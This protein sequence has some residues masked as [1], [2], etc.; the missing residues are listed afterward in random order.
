[1]NADAT[2]HLQHAAGVLPDDARVLFDR[3]SHA[4][5]F[6]LPIYQAVR[7]TASAKPNRFIVRIPTEEKTNAEAEQL[8]RRALEIDA[9]YL[10]ARVRLARLLD[11][12][13]QHD[14]AAAQVS[15]ALESQPE[16][17]AGFYALIVAGR[18]ATAR[19]RY[20]EALQH[21]SAALLIYPGA[22]SA[23]LGASHAAL[24]HADLSRTL[25]PIEHLAERSGFAD[26]PWLD[27][28]LGAGRDVNALMRGLWARV[29]K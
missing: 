13:G 11:R 23:S 27:Y 21:Y 28:Q 5:T 17:V 14:E 22:Q 26:D 7:E 24:M 16:G 18:V 8:Y 15:R 1:M 20:D 19:R 29:P 3:G 25:A 4:E 10:E 9:G 6:G 2:A 12:R